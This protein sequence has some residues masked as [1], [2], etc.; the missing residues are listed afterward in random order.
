MIAFDTNFLVRL[1]VV[2]DAAQ[3]QIVRRLVAENSVFISNTVL[4][5]TEWVLR[6]RYKETPAD[7]HSFFCAVLAA[8][9]T[10]FE[11]SETITQALDWYQLGAD[12]ADALHL[13]AC[14]KTVMHTFDQNFCSAARNVGAAPEVRVWHT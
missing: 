2:D 11:N 4:L 5:E 9:Q 12:F 1:A 3:V 14:G 8:E 6:S 10:S 7:I 13:V